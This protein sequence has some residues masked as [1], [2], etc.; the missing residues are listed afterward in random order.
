M[1]VT[2]AVSA[3]LLVL[4][5]LAAA[6]AEA[7]TV[8]RTVIRFAEP[9]G[10]PPEE[11]CSR[12]ALCPPGTVRADVRALPGELNEVT[13]TVGAGSVVV[14]RD[15]GAPL[16]AGEGC[17]ARPDGAV[18]CSP[19]EPGAWSPA[20]RVF[21]GD[22]DDTLVASGVTLRAGGGEGNDV[23]RGGP[24]LDTLRGG[25]GDDLLIGGPGR[26]RLFGGPNRD[27]LRGGAGRDYLS[28]RDAGPD[29]V[30]GGP[31]T[32]RARADGADTLRSVEHLDR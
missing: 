26:D 31:D 24:G 11:S 9:V 23:L 10:T 18:A 14:V 27:T 6:P 3:V 8:S 17:A 1:A 15:A 28:A 30:F 22:Q 19:P 2:R 5:A 20:A 29:R 13:V 12:Y 32:D 25:P 4:I 7:A 21:L 16:I